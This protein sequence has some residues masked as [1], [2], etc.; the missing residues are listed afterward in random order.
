MLSASVLFA[1]SQCTVE[2]AAKQFDPLAAMTCRPGEG[3]VLRRHAP[4]DGE[5]EEFAAQSPADHTRN[6]RSAAWRTAWAIE[7]ADPRLPD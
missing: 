7:L 4:F 3:A 5:E 2:P 6:G 1:R